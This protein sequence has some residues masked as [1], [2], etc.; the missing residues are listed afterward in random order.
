[1]S[2]FIS[3]KNAVENN[4]KS[5]NVEIPRNKI[6][7]ITGVSGSGK[8]TLAFNTIYAEGQRRYIESLSTY[9][10]RFIGI[11]NKPM[12]ESIT[13]LSPTLAI[14]Q[15]THSHTYQPTVSTITEIHD[16]I[17]LLFAKI[18]I[19]YSLTTNKPI[20]IYSHEEIKNTVAVFPTDTMLHIMSPIEN[21]NKINEI[22]NKGFAR[23]SI[24]GAIY[25][26]NDNYKIKN[27]DNVL[28]I[29]DR[30]IIKENIDSRILNDLQ[31]AAEINKKLIIIAKFANKNQ[32]CNPE[33]LTFQTS[34]PDSDAN[35]VPISSIVPSLF[36]FNNPSGACEE[37]A[38]LGIAP[39]IN[40]NLL[41]PDHEKT[42][43]EGALAPLIAT[44]SHNIT[45]KPYST[46][47]EIFTKLAKK[48]SFSLNA[49]WREL[50]KKI[51]DILLYGDPSKIF[52][53]LMTIVEISIKAHSR[54]PLLKNDPKKYTS[55]SKCI[56]CNGYR[57]NKRALSIKI[58][59][60]S[61]GEINAMTAIDAKHFFTDYI[62]N[63]CKITSSKTLIAK[64][65]IK[66]IIKR[67]TAINDIGLGYLTLNRSIK[68]LSGGE[69]QRVRLVS[70]IGM[71]LSGIL[72]VLDEPSIGLHHTE[73]EKLVCMVKELKDMGNTILIVEHD[74]AI[75]KNADYVIEIG[76]GSGEK[77]GNIV[78]QGTI[79]EIK[80]NSHSLTG[81]YL[82]RKLYITMP[83]QRRISDKK[84]AVHGIKKH[85]IKNLDVSFPLYSLTCITGSSGTGKSTLAANVIYNC[86]KENGKSID[87][88]YEKAFGLEYIDGIVEVNHTLLNS[89]PRSNPATYMN[90][91]NEIKNLFA[92]QKLS[93]SLGY[94]ASKF[95]FNSKNGHCKSCEG[96]GMIKIDMH[97]LSDIYI[98]CEHC[99]GKRYNWEALQVTYKGKNISDVLSMTVDDALLFF[100]SFAKIT[101]GLTAVQE[102]GLGYL[103][104]G[105]PANT[106]SG[107][108]S[109]R[110]KIAKELV[111]YSSSRMLYILDEPTTGL[112]SHDIKILI[113]ALN[114]L[115]D[116]NNTMIV[117]EHNINIIK[118]ADYIIEMGLGG[119]E[120]GGK[121][122]S[123]GT[124]EE[125]IKNKNSKIKLY[126]DSQ[127]TNP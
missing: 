113:K 91:F 89:T 95:S 115:V 79:D 31:V 121:I 74:E 87:G 51:Q 20:K 66:E 94:N 29:I 7:V 78:A 125:L 73:S 82:S 30:I 84:I 1:M 108:E 96:I 126:F 60:L 48:Y 76:P 112:H 103:K 80:Q 25:T 39:S 54:H 63:H 77:G 123:Q 45:I 65:I 72:Y 17:R 124:P 53:G 58:S 42:L 86:I 12:V 92:A 118:N 56:T 57:M 37:C 122:I 9:L 16:H 116:K 5:I 21:H 55:M 111:K 69:V 10:R 11:S 120:M 43:L 3:I 36:S 62:K 59:D 15:K 52:I 100:A 13:G 19:P 88:T 24:N 23:L 61:I 75:I 38:G 102:V 110:I 47:F 101:K 8:S 35:A 106:L 2:K 119:G 18:G 104:L 98:T 41:V 85:N 81:M 44:S 6:T 109:Q 33:I 107:G 99:N 67:L 50:P 27:T 4:L 68:T 14:S 90:I 93:K 71:G 34:S 117:I 28:V 26:D 114:K 127:I 83:A 64:Q 46:L 105:Q 97:F 40:P 70:Q 22:K 32:T 49:P